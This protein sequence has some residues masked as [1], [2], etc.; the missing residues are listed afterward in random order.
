MRFRRS[1]FAAVLASVVL[2][3]PAGALARQGAAGPAQAM[4]GLQH[5]VRVVRDRLG[6]PHVYARSDHDAFFVNG[7]LHAQDR[8][9]EM[10]DLRRRADGTRAELLGPGSGDEVLGFDVFVRTLGLRRAAERSAAAY[11]DWVIADLRAY[12]DGVNLWLARNPL[13]AEYTALELTKASVPRWTPVD[14]IL[15]FKFI[16]ADLSLFADFE[17]MANTELLTS[18]ENAGRAGG[19][20]GTKLFFDDVARRQPFDPTVSIPT[21]GAKR[22]SR[23]ARRAHP[24]V[25]EGQITGLA[26]FMRRGKALGLGRPAG[27]GSNWW[28]VSGARSATG[29]PLLAGDPHL[30]LSSPPVWHE[31][32]LNVTGR[33]DAAMNVYGTG[34]PGVPGVVHGFNDHV[35]WSSTTHQLDVSDFFQERVVVEDSLPVATLYKGVAEPLVAVPET[36]RANR[37]DGTP[38]NGPAL[39]A[40]LRSSGVAVPAATFVVPRLNNG[41][42]I[43][44]PAGPAGEETAI[45]V[46]FTGFSATRELEAVLRFDRANRLG[47]FKRALQ[48]FDVGSQNWAVADTRGNIA[49]W[50]SA[51]APLREDLQAG[52]VAGLPPFFVRD[53]TG[54]LPNGWI[55]DAHPAPDQAVPYE[56]LPFAE[57]PQVVNPARG[58]VA[59]A[60]NDPVGTTLDNDPLNQL[61]PGGG[62]YYLGAHYDSNRVARITRLLQ[63]ALAGGRRVSR[64]DMGRI[65]DDVTLVDAQ[66]FEPFVQRAYRDAATAGAAPQLAALAADPALAE[67]VRR[68]AAWDG[69]T[70]TGIADGYD[71][72]DVAG[73]RRAPT[74]DE[75]SNSVAATIYALWRGRIL[76]NTIVAT[77]ER[78]GLGAAVPP[79]DGMIAGLRRLLDTFADTHG[80]GASGLNFF[81]APGVAAAPEA[82]RD[83]I[84]LKSLREALDLASGPAFAPAFGGSTNQDDYRWGKLHR[85][86]F[87]HPLGGAFSMPPGAGFTDLAPG[88]PGIATDG[89]YGTVDAAY[90]DP[91]AASADGFMFDHGPSRRFIGE[92]APSGIRA[93]QVIAGGESGEPADPWFGNQLGL[94]L[95]NEAHP[96]LATKR[97]VAGGAAATD[98]L[99]PGG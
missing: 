32:G 96:A 14:S 19:F 35:M 78:A 80:V 28:L 82:E 84:I 39:V 98:V 69:S 31:I 57:M 7:Y 16:S 1:A 63:D 66:V 75:V 49:Y 91:R 2:G 59:N 26:E 23:R 94:W 88:L 5:P 29:F 51:E 25:R 92:A 4:P 37:L 58:F 85:I 56:V 20:D 8:L 70:P 30:A 46:A 6:V 64:A 21:S 12:A 71:A 74:A 54:G 33:Q 13:P 79:D 40:G 15:I 24:A 43:T 83:L 50:T 47:D 65:Q 67:A 53:G 42:L 55:P 3:A 10:D 27:S 41:P 48:F 34:F 68:L 36:F 86:A 60:N 90:H 22:A 72:S 61:R 38:D 99:V 11:P 45:G 9:F 87:A 89:G 44:P 81:D 77:L 17:D 97:D 95:T 18:Y 93:T 76:E 62:I 52:A 73:V